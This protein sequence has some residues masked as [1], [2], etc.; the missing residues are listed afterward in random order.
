L[1]SSEMSPKPF[2]TALAAIMCAIPHP[3]VIIEP[4]YNNIFATISKPIF[5]CL[6]FR[7]FRIFRII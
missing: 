4:I 6:L 1:L 2:T 3:M 7:I 5:Y